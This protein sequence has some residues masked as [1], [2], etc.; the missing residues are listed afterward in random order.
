MGIISSFLTKY[1]TSSEIKLFKQVKGKIFIDSVY[2]I[3]RQI[4]IINETGINNAD[5]INMCGGIIAIS[6]YPILLIKDI[7]QIK[8]EDLTDK[9]MRGIDESKTPFI[10]FRYIVNDEM[11]FEILYRCDDTWYF[12][13]GIQIC[14]GYTCDNGYALITER[15]FRL[16]VD[17][18]V[19]FWDQ[20]EDFTQCVKLI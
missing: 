1:I 16:M 15:I 19:G 2:T 18:P 20:R 4:A 5:I 8:L 11:D 9:I 7:T 17:K 13:H 12:S 10:V 6:K 14:M 3:D